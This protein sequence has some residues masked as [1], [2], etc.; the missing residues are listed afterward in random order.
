MQLRHVFPIIANS[1]V[2]AC[3]RPSHVGIVVTTAQGCINR[4]ILP[5]G[6]GACG[7]SSEHVE[8]MENAEKMDGDVLRFSNLDVLRFSENPAPT[9]MCSGSPT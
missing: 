4:S 3:A 7:V 8:N 9:E 5:S 1:A 2:A 6:I